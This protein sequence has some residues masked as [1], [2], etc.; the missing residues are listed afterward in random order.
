MWS[1]SKKTP[2]DH[3]N[4]ILKLRGYVYIGLKCQTYIFYIV[5]LTAIYQLLRNNR[6]RTKKKFS[7]NLSLR[8]KQI[9]LKIEQENCENINLF[10]FNIHFVLITLIF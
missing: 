6:L 2:I 3:F 5:T 7:I 4:I 10:H 8:K 9:F 1:I